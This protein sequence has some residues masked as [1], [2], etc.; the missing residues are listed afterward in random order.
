MHV[1]QW[2]VITDPCSNFKSDSA[3]ELEVSEWM[4]NYIN[5]T[6]DVISYTWPCICQSMLEKGAIEYSEL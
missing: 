5:Q 3:K 6:L 4:N 2:S 1:K